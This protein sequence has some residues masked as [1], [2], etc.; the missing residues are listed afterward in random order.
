MAIRN[1]C[2]FCNVVF[3][4]NNKKIKKC[5][6]CHKPMKISRNGYKQSNYVLQEGEGRQYRTGGAAC[7]FCPHCHGNRNWCPYMD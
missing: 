6:I 4:T 1:R 2:I 5:P 7:D 3:V